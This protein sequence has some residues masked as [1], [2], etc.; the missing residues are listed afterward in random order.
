MPKRQNKAWRKTSTYKKYKHKVTK[1]RKPNS[2]INR[3]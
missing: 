1:A 2:T 3:K